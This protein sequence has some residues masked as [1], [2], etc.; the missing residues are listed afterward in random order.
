MSGAHLHIENLSYRYARPGLFSRAQRQGTPAVNDVSLTV[1]AGETL[2]L[3][4]ESGS[5]KSTIARAIAGLLP[6]SAGRMS[7]G[8][9][10]L[11]SPIER[12]SADL[13]RLIQ[14]IFQNPDA[15]LNRRHRIGTILARPLQLFFGLSGEKLRNEVRSLLAAVQLPQDYAE[16]FPGEISGGER[17]R[18]AIARALAARPALL[19]CDEIV[20]ALDVSVQAAVLALLRSLQGQSR[21]SMLF[22]THDLAVVRWFADRVAVL[23]RG[24]LCEVG[25]VERVFAPPFHPYTALLLEAVP[26]SGT[27][28]AGAPAHAAEFSVRQA[29]GCPFAGQCRH[30]ID[31]LC[32]DVDPPWRQIAPGHAIRCHLPQGEPS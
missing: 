4:G 27:Q 22:I 16:R 25:P 15:S 24:H 12:R 1:K 5:G 18:V 29:P 7:F 32:R 30:R 13:R 11:P 19:L 17:Q 26:G 6:V 2:A 9:D 28:I 3:V 31:G 23:Y 20:S 21:L 14:F 8:G 10:D